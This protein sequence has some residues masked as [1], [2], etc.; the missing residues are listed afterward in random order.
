MKKVQDMCVTNVIHDCPFCDSEHK[1]EIRK[2][3]STMLIKNEPVKFERTI[4]Y[5]PI[6]NEEFA[7]AK[8]MDENMLAAND[9]Y[10]KMKGLLTTGEIKKI[11]Q[12]YDLTQ[13]ELANLLGWGGA[14][15]QRYETKLIQDE[16]YDSILRMIMDNPGYA[17]DL[18]SKHKELF[19]QDRYGHI[20]EAI[21]E[22]IR[23]VGLLYSVKQQIRNLY[24]NYDEPMDYNGQKILDLDK[25]DKAIG[26]FANF[27]NPL[28]KVKTMKLLWFTDV[29]HYN[30][31]GCSVTGLVYKH[32]PLGAVPIAFNEI[33]SLPSIKVFEEYGYGENDIRY[34]II[35]NKVIGIDSFSIEEIEVLNKVVGFFKDMKTQD[36]VDYMHQ[37]KAYEITAQNDIIPFSLTKDLRNF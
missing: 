12:C 22:N 4:Y 14:T 27:I 1:M 20:R 24:T 19:E 35:P 32:L 10:R 31:F 9:E 30:R 36:I 34:R 11:R 23:E 13:K 6:A 2:G 28:Y 21:K 18:L 5:C 25:V 15:I 3:L 29:V 7:P 26:F 16:T 17:L 33:L 8:I 37:E